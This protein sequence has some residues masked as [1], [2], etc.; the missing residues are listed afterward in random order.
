MVGTLCRAGKGVVECL[1]RS[2][3]LKN[4]RKLFPLPNLI[5]YKRLLSD[6]FFIAEGLFF[7]RMYI[8]LVFR[9]VL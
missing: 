5:I 7:V 8:L 4:D 6:K 2:G 9:R 1:Y 3:V